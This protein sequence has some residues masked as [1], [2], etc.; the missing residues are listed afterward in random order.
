MLLMAIALCC[1]GCGGGGRGAT[2]DTPADSVAA[3]PPPQNAA[4]SLARARAVLAG[5]AARDPQAWMAHARQYPDSVFKD[6]HPIDISWSPADAG[7]VSDAQ[8]KGHMG[9]ADAKRLFQAEGLQ[10][11]DRGD[12]PEGRIEIHRDR[13]KTSKGLPLDIY[14]F[15]AP[16]LQWVADLYFAR[17][18]HVFAHKSVFHKYGL[19]MGAISHPDHDLVW[20]ATEKLESGTGIWWDMEVHYGLRGDSLV[21]L[22]A[23]ELEVNQHVF[24]TGRNWWLWGHDEPGKAGVVCYSW[25]VEIGGLYLE[26]GAPWLND[27]T[28]VTYVPQ[29]RGMPWKPTFADQKLNAEK[30]A[31]LSLYGGDSLFIHAWQAE[32]KAALDAADERTRRAA[33][34]YLNLVAD[35][36]K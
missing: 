12:V 11:L 21:P 7:L 13:L 32:L 18:T 34:G 2:T 36:G 14:Q 9:L 4:D 23:Y 5:I 31:S 22:Y 35:E 27:S 28:V 24:P 8:R 26:D 1:L 15:G 33:V 20:H 29:A 30:L 25:E 10:D 6:L 19:E 17:G 16:G 3:I